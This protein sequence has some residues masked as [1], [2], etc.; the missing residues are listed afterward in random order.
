[1]KGQYIVDR[2]RIVLHDA[3]GTRWPDSELVLWI[4]DGC[5]YIAIARPD[6]CAVNASMS[7]A[8]GS[9]QSIAAL[10]PP[11]VRL[12][13]VVRTAAGRA[14][15]IADRQELD[16]WRP[17]WHADTAG[18]TEN[19]VYD[20]RDP[21]NFYV[22]PPATAGDQIHII[23]SRVPLEITT[24]QLGSTDLSINDL[25]ADAMLNYVL[26]RCYAKDAEET[27]NA[28]LASLYLQACNASLG[29]KTGADVAASPDL[30]SPG[31]KVS[32]GATTGGV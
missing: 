11:G 20:N 15:T 32:P 12:L 8:A 31:A 29:I 7:L 3:A 16:T 27:H 18:P 28:D 9:K 19:Y 30:N 2:A 26:F 10:N 13:D 25:Y 4:N 23:Y 24:G 14:I 1:M 22:W 21:Q 17:T 5:K 6:A